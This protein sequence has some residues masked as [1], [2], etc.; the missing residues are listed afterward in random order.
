MAIRAGLLLLAAASAAPRAFA[1]T[2][3]PADW[4]QGTTLSAFAGAASSA[5]TT[6][7]ATGLSVGWEL[8]PRF[9]VEGRTLWIRGG[10]NA[11]AFAATLAARVAIR[12]ARPFVPFVSAGLGLY[13]ASFDPAT[14]DVPEF[15]RRRLSAVGLG[16]QTFTDPMLSVGGGADFFLTRH[17]ALRPEVH[18]LLAA[19]RSDVRAVAVYGAQLAYHFESHPVTPHRR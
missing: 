5:E 6:S 2:A 4:Q 8:T 1:Q 17:L 7:G 9:G 3:E 18:L 15:Y 19:A 14:S 12:P 11:D 10:S 16:T 13:R